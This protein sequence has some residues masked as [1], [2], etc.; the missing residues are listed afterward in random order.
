MYEFQP[1]VASYYDGSCYAPKQLIRA[2]NPWSGHYAMDIGFW[3][4]MHFSR[5]RKGLD[6]CK[7]CLLW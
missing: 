5:L 7:R 3:M 6:V 1:A 4:A 2:W